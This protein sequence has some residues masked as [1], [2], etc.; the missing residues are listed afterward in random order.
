MAPLSRVLTVCDAALNDVGPII[1]HAGD[2]PLVGTL[3]SCELIGFM[4]LGEG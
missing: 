3:N 4:Q 1:K 2:R